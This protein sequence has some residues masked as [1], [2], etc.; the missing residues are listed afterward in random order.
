MIGLKLDTA[1]VRELFPE[2]SE[3]RLEL[4]R[5]VI[6]NIAKD[7]LNT[8]YRDQIKREIDQFMITNGINLNSIVKEEVEKYFNRNRFEFDPETT[9]SKS[10]IM[11]L[12]ES[13]K[14]VAEQVVNGEVYEIQKNAASKLEEKAI[15]SVSNTIRYNEEKLK[16]IVREELAK[17]YKQ[18]AFDLIDEKMKAE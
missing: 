14:K 8:S 18:L 4:Q 5:A 9:T 13:L 1:S 17:R 15:E 10:A 16:Q 6:H 12:R 2:G 3:V 11:K 7:L